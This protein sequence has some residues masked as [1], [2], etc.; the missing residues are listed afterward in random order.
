M[1][2]SHQN[3]N[4]SINIINKCMNKLK[5]LNS[6]SILNQVSHIEV[7][8]NKIWQNKQALCMHLLYYFLIINENEKKN[9]KFVFVTQSQF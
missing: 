9:K 5:T 3:A 6:H 4:K 1:K 7:T 8:I 2:E